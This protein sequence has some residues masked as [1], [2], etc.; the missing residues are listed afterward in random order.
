MSAATV[1][2]EVVA[3][4]GVLGVGSILGQYVGSSKDRREAR[5][6]VLSALADTESSRWV[7]PDS[8]T[9]LGEFQTSMRKLQTAALVARLPRDAVWE[10]AVLAQAA[11]WL[12]EEE[13]ELTGDPDTGGAIDAS[14]AEAAREAARAIAAMAWSP[15]PLHTWR[16]RRAKK[17]ID[18]LLT[19][20][21]SARE[22]SAVKRSRDT[23]FM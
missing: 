3:V 5:A 6:G 8:K 14:L 12:S 1:I 7:G 20:L 2:A 23:G 21:Q 9:T 17:R 19:K 4:L 15:A 11:R 18:E 16:W 10:Y 22:R 13:W